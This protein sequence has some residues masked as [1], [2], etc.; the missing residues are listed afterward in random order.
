MGPIDHEGPLER[1]T[2]GQNPRSCEHGGRGWRDWGQGAETCGWRLEARKGEDTDCSR[3]PPEGRQ[4]CPH[5]DVGP[6]KLIL[7]F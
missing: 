5:L 3:E 7:D 1:E 6:A 2:G 4:F